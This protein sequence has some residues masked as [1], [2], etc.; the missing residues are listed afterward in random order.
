MNCPNGAGGAGSYSDPGNCN[1]YF[2]CTAGNRN[3]S[4]QYCQSGTLFSASL[5]RCVVVSRADCSH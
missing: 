3:P 5:R 4:I 1:R 2:Y